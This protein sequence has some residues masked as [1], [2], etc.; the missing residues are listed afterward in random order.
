MSDVTVNGC[1][2]M[3]T[4]C[5]CDSINLHCVNWGVFSRLVCSAALAFLSPPT[6]LHPALRQWGTKC[7]SEV[8]IPYQLNWCNLC[9]EGP[10]DGV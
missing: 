6:I 3:V 1:L 9:I 2:P 10:G 4:H 8:Q 7:Q 5:C